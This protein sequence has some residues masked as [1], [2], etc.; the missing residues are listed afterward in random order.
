M[1]GLKETST[2][3]TTDVK[4]FEIIPYFQI[5]QDKGEITFNN[6]NKWKLTPNKNQGFTLTVYIEV[7]SSFC[8]RGKRVLCRTPVFSR[9]IPVCYE[10]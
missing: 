7:A 1:R 4:L 10:A 3:T 2:L 8:N 5:L 9:I 6:N